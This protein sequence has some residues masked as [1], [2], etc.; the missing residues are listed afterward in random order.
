LEHVKL[1]LGN[2]KHSKQTYKKGWSYYKINPR[3]QGELSLLHLQK[4]NKKIKKGRLNG[5]SLET[6]KTRGLPNSMG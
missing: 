4:K 1:G 3:N 5:T 2:H 6:F